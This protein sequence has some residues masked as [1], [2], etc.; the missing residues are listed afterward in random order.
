M[1]CLC[2]Y[3]SDRYDTTE[4]KIFDLTS[5]NFNDIINKN[6]HV[7]IDFWAPWCGPCQVMLPIYQKLSKKYGKNITFA[8]INIDQNKTIASTYEIYSIPSF[9]LFKNGQPINGIFGAV[10]ESRL[11]ELIKS[12]KQ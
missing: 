10:T 1:V 2:M 12:I 7:L 5:Y 4:N 3:L 8:R 9:I 11:E 6:E